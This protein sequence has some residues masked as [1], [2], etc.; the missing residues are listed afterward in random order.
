MV[1]Y[2]K[3]TGNRFRNLSKNKVAFKNLLLQMDN[4][5]PH[6]AA[7]TQAYLKQSG[8]KIVCQSPYSPDLN[9]CD[10][11]LFTRLQHHCR[12][13]EY[14]NG[15]E[16]YIDEKRYLRSLPEQLLLHELSKLLEHCRTLI[17]EA[18]AYVTI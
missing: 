15:E 8:V 1:E 9:L 18:G 2:F 4:A 14:S 16:L 11:F 12:E 5:K 3:D 13:Q 6:S 17:R 7:R 10:R